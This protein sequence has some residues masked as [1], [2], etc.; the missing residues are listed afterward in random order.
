MAAE[1]LVPEGAS[2]G[3]AFLSVLAFQAVLVFSWVLTRRAASTFTEPTH[4]WY[5]NLQQ[6]WWTVKPYWLTVSMLSLNFLFQSLAMYSVI[7]KHAEAPQGA[8]SIVTVVLLVLALVGWLH[9]TFG[10]RNLRVAHIF[11]IFALLLV[12]ITLSLMANMDIE[13]GTSL[14]GGLMIVPLLHTLYLSLQALAVWHDNKNVD[15]GKPSAPIV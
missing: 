10:L 1:D 5:V 14:H 9:S 7:V 3:G 6:R 4:L 2:G 8:G 13:A 15:Y 12:I 11:S